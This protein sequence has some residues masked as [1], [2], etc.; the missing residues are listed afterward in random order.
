VS[1]LLPGHVEIKVRVKP[2]MKARVIAS[3]ERGMVV[4]CGASLDGWLQ[5]IGSWMD[6]WMDGWMEGGREG[7]M[8]NMR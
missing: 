1:D 4:R 8:D 6:G 7:W 3:L 2:H 5:V